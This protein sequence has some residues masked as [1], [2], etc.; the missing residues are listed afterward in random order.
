ML[1]N[2]SRSLLAQVIVSIVSVTLKD[3]HKSQNELRA[4]QPHIPFPLSLT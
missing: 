4:S 3:L 2:L 1:P